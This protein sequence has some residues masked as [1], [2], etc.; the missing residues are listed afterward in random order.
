MLTHLIISIIWVLL[1]AISIKKYL[2]AEIPNGILTTED[3]AKL[4]LISLLAPVIG[5]V[6]II[7]TIIAKSINF[8][9]GSENGRK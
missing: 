7:S 2:T 8:F 1:A 9:R 5:P 6:L 3:G 4:L